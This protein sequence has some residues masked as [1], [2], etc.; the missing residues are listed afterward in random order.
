MKLFVLL[1]LV[2]VGLPASLRDSGAG[3]DVT[4]STGSVSNSNSHSNLIRYF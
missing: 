4:D 2:H 3:S 1:A